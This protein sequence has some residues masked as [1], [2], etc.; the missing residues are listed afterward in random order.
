MKLRDV[1]LSVHG[2]SLV[3]NRTHPVPVCIAIDSPGIGTCSS[4]LIGGT[5]TDTTRR[6]V[7]APINNHKSDNII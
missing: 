5:N 6:P 7:I 2:T 4:F 1:A 3:L